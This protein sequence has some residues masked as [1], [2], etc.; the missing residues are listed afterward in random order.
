[1]WKLKPGA[2]IIIASV[3]AGLVFYWFYSQGSMTSS[4][5]IIYSAVVLAVVVVLVNNLVPRLRKR[6]MQEIDREPKKRRP[7]D[8]L[9]A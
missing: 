4:L 5:G 2:A 6:Q 9:K 7:T 1:M 8:N 3:G